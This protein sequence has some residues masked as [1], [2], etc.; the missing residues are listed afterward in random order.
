MRALQP[1]GRETEEVIDMETAIPRDT[2]KRDSAASWP[3][4]STGPLI[5]GGVLLGLGAL[6]GLAGMVIAGSH[7]AA[8]TRQWVGDMDVP[9]SEL[10]KLKWEQAR[11]AAA[12][13]T[14]TWR[15]HPNAKVGFNQR[16][17]TS[18]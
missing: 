5:A 16:A 3:E 2:V 11:S 1:A 4:F 13:G 7:L 6:F 14:E 18:A 17:R 12:A 10:A 9:P 8:A 15:T